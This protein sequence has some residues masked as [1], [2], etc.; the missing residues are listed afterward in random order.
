MSSF[1]IIRASMN[2][3]FTFCD[4]IKVWVFEITSV[5]KTIQEYIHLHLRNITLLNVT[6]PLISQNPRKMDVLS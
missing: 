1:E 2:E 6:P 5:F 4:T 3:D